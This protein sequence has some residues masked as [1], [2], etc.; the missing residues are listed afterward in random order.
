[1]P[2]L[3][4]ADDGND[5]QP[6]DPISNIVR[7]PSP[8]LSSCHPITLK[9]TDISYRV[10][11]ESRSK[12]NLR[13]MIRGS[14][15]TA[16]VPTATIE[17]RVILNGVTGMA[18]PG[19]ILA[20]LGPSGS[21]KS[22]LL[23]ALAGRIDGHSLTGSIL[24]NDRKLTKP[25]LKRTGFVT[26][27]DV[28]YPHL[29]VRETLTFC[30]L[31]R[32]PTSISREEKI[33][34][35]ETVLSELGLE[36]CADTL[37]GNGFVCGVS[38]GERK[39]VSIA[40]EVLINPSLLI[41][42]EPT[43]SLDSTAAY[44]LVVTLSGLARKGKTIVMAVHQPSSRVYQ[45]FDSVLLMSEGRGLYYGKGSE[46]MT[47]FEGVGF[48]PSFPMNPADFFLDLA[49]G[50]YHVDSV[51]EKEKLNMK[52]TLIS[53]Y[54]D[55]LAPKVK[56]TC[57]ELDK[58]STTPKDM[59]IMGGHYPEQH[60][61]V[62]SISMWFSHFAILLQRSLKD[63]KH[64]S[65]DSLRV[66]Q[67]LAAAMLAGAIW[68]RSDYQDIQDRLGLFFFISIFWGVFPS[69]NAV[70]AFPQDRA[71]F[72]KERSSGMYTLSP[73]FMARVVGDLPM[74]L[75]LPMVFLTMIYWMATLKPDP[76]AFM[77]T[78][79]LVLGYVLVAQ[80]LGLAIGAIMMDAKR[81]ATIAT[82]TM[83]AFVLT[84]GFYVHHIPGCL[85]WI[86]YTSI[87]YYC[88]R[89]LIYV[90]Y[91]EGKGISSLLGCSNH[92]RHA[93]A[94]CKFIEDDVG[95]QISAMASVGILVLMLVGYRLLAYLALS[96]I[97]L[98]TR[99]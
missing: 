4:D 71:I 57:L 29:T 5:H 25:V 88:Y 13:H 92:W 8:L 18:N 26:Q 96:R 91:G 17:E 40:H 45:V 84:G 56:A 32:L 66:V 23:N 99:Q 77:L 9:F 19:E 97:K 11:L 42:D 50:V 22:T 68:W 48:S 41:L 43:S 78:L 90:Q 89:L 73:Y 60:P 46:A 75:I 15:S 51:T 12:S 6:F 83:L 47:Y 98:R 93:T 58:T 53:S 3:V 64:E 31:L 74:E 30:A 86:K 35:A 76:V 85:A 34:A 52:Q 81:A 1:M 20:I 49:N 2:S 69:F 16:Q 82:I 61:P 80:G 59:V 55:L 95:G 7:L 14:G 70:F 79:A 28:F 44:R 37:I 36:K 94:S 33:V 27:D 72:L 67:V 54:N 62:T 65:F 10:K 87:T 63:R 38:G 21:G 39:R 24:A